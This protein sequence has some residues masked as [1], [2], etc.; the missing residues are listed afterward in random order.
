MRATIRLSLLPQPRQILGR[1]R[2]PSALFFAREYLATTREVLGDD[3]FPDG[4]N[5][6]RAMLER[7]ADYS[8]EQGLT[9]EKPKIEELF[10][11]STRDL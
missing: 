2:F 6:N 7:L 5:A 8:H 1:S 10:A 9:Q 11:K 4:V 3:P